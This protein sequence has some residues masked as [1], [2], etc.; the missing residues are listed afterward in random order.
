MFKQRLNRATIIILIMT[1]LLALATMPAMS[2]GKGKDKGGD[3]KLGCQKN[4][5]ERVDC[6]SLEVTGVCEANAAVFTIRNTG[7]PGDG[8]M[9]S[10]TQYRL[11]VDGVVVE[12]GSVQLGGGGTMTIRYS[13]PGSTV[14]LEADQQVGHPGN[15]RPQVTLSCQPAP[16]AVPPTAVPP[17]AVP[18]TA[19]PPTAVPP[20]AV[21]PTDEPT[22]EPTEEPT[23]QPTEEPTQEPTAEPTEEP[24]PDPTQPNL[25]VESSCDNSGNSIIVFV[26]TNTGADMID[27]LWYVVRDQSWNTIEEGW[28]LLYSGESIVLNYSADYSPLTL[29]VGDYL[30]VKTQDCLNPYYDIFPYCLEDGGFAFTVSNL[31]MDMWSPEA[32]TVVDQDNNLVESGEIFLMANDFITLTYPPLY[33]SLSFEVG[34]GLGV[35]YLA[36][37]P[38]DTEPTPEPTQEPTVEPTPMPTE[39]QTPEPTHVP[40][41]PGVLGCQKN[42]PERLDCS[43]LQVRAV[44]EGDV[45]VFTITNTGEPGN[46]DMLAATNYYLFVSGAVIDSGDVLLEG[47]ATMEIRYEGGERA[48]LQ[49]NQQVGHPGKSLPRATIQC[50]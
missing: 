4:N 26:V 22:D 17:T 20:T 44:C 8:D 49:A 19:V 31:G 14:T 37:Q 24:T 41:E 15:S 1:V 10:A 29:Y 27:P 12:S 18:P 16:T 35:G 34:G 21:P 38:P 36:C 48:T 11:I 32:Y 46:G 23:D 6:S 9:R 30:I 43:S 40:T 2:Q 39:E 7:E 33:T 47:G 3:G 13:G 45:A 50:D 25:V 5:P 42:N 28:I